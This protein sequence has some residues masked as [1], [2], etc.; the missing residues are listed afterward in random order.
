[1]AYQYPLSLRFKIVAIASQIFVQ[2][3]NGTDVLYIKR[4]AFKLKEDVRVCQDSTQ[5]V[6]LY[7]MKA[8]R[9]L[10]ISPRFTITDRS[11]ATIG[12][13]KREGLRS[14]WRASYL[15][16]DAQGTV[17]HHIKEENPWMKVLD[18]LLSEIPILGMLTSW[19]IHPSYLVLESGAEVPAYRLTKRPALFEGRFTIEKLADIPEE[20]TEERL[21]L[22]QMLM[23]MFER[24]RG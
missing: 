19:L 1:M 22:G 6:E 7:T 12:A 17:T 11:G 10:D 9:V 2:D 14:L 13:I 20:A 18:A 21:V 16:E 3:A 4:K 15:L 5:S 24:S 23:V 8:D